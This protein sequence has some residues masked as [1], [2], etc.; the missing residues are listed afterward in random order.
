MDRYFIVRHSLRRYVMVKNV[1]S[2][3]PSRSIF[4]TYWN[5]TKKTSPSQENSYRGRES[6]PLSD[7]LAV[8]ATQFIRSYG[9]ECGGSLIGGRPFAQSSTSLDTKQ[10]NVVHSEKCY[11]F[12]FHASYQNS[13]LAGCDGNKFSR[14]LLVS[15]TLLL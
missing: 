3:A 9:K 1:C 6:F 15:C 11:K 14:Y 5:N 12:G 4:T 8:R 2:T 13:W 7:N 10:K